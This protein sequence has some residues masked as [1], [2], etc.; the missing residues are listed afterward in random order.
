MTVQIT[1]EYISRLLN[2]PVNELEKIDIALSSAQ[3]SRL[4]S[5]LVGNG[6]S[7]NESV[8]QSKFTVD[9]LL[10]NA[11]ENSIKSHPQ[12]P[13]SQS[14]QLY[15]LGVQIGVDMQRIDEL[16]PEGMPFDPKSDDG[17]AQIFTDKEL[18]YAQSK[19]NPEEVLTGIFCAKE[20][21][22]KASQLIIPLNE[23]EVL[24]DGSGQPK[25][26][27]FAISISHSGEYA[28]AIAMYTSNSTCLIMRNEDQLPS[29]EVDKKSFSGEIALW[30][31]KIRLIDFFML[32]III[33]LILKSK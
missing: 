25:T 20:A 13:S 15:G 21:V 4:H 23:I 2:K 8:L 26:K 24:P 31:L 16:F 9:K 29:T 7:F 10:G 3:K 6:I 28:L 5:W 32:G 12:E 33:F 30:G 22:Q 27:D 14:S 18:S 17:L 1:L 19:A 11:E